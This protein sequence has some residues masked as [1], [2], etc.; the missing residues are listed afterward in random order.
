MTE[1]GKRRKAI[2]NSLC[3]K[4]GRPPTTRAFANACG[5]SKNKGDQFVRYHDLATS[6][7][8]SGPHR[9]RDSYD[10][11]FN[12]RVLEYKSAEERLGRLPS[13]DELSTAWG[14]RYGTA[15]V[16]I[17]HIQRTRGYTFD[18]TNKST[19]LRIAVKQE[20]M[21]IARE[22]KDGEVV[23]LADLEIICKASPNTIK[24]VIRELRDDG[25]YIKI[26][27]SGG[28]GEHNRN[29]NG[30][31]ARYKDHSE[32]KR[33]RIKVFQRSKGRCE[34]CGEKAVSVHHVDEDK[35]NHTL[36]N[37]LAVCQACHM[38]LHTGPNAKKTT[39]KYRREFGY[40]LQEIADILG[41]SMSWVSSLNKKDGAA[42]VKSMIHE[43]KP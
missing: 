35:G 29:W 24:K 18:I 9:S 17:A 7:P 10:A 41:C 11:L 34:I 25:V 21:E 1:E 43:I 40:S 22:I 37:L 20:L 4:E 26:G 19:L 30:G 38:A 3:S 23:A 33:Q 15:S 16:Y 6:N 12:Q 42:I 2:Y 36:D 28:V 32:L 27:R 13:M 8:V 39:S 31:V 5:I 14:C